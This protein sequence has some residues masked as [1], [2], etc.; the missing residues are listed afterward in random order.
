MRR[1]RRSTGRRIMLVLCLCLAA[2]L[3]CVGTM[4][5]T[6]RQYKKRYEPVLLEKEQRILAAE[7]RVFVTTGFV[8]AGEELSRENCAWMTVLSDQPQEL[9]ADEVYGKTACADIAGG[10]QVL[11]ALCCEESYT[12]TQRENVAEDIAQCENFADYDLV[13]VRIRYPNGEN[14][15]VLQKKRLRKDEGKPRQHR[16]ILSEA[17]MI[18]LS[19]A[20][21]DVETYRG[22]ELYFVAF[23]EE[24]LQDRTESRYIPPKQEITQLL[25]LTEENEANTLWYS[26]R[27]ELEVRL[28]EESEQRLN[29]LF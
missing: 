4:Y 25:E 12:A 7:R 29:R 11:A 18:L 28:L 10:T 20:R 27:Q 26:Y 2:A 15:C 1:I 5:Y 22:C 14:Y 19:G 3:L 21:Y 17:E 16:L 23:A 8:S 24:R 9:F 6:G 13:D